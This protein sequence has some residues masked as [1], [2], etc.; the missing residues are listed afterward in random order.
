ME[1]NAK[2]FPDKRLDVQRTV[3]EGNLVTVHSRVRLT[4]AGPDISVVHLFRFE[5]G[6]IAELWDLGVAASADMVNGAGLF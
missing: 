3:A 5:E 1:A 2:Q 4:S 6:R